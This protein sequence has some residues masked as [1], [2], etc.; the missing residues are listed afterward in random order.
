M[1]YNSASRSTES[2]AQRNAPGIAAVQRERFKPHRHE[3]TSLDIMQIK[4]V[5]FTIL[6]V[7]AITASAVQSVSAQGNAAVD[8]AKVLR[9]AGDALGMNRW[10]DIG[11]G[12]T[13]L[14]A[15]DI[16]NTMEFVGSGTSYSS[17]QTFKTDYHVTLGYNPPA[18]RVEMA[19][20]GSGGGA[21][22]HSI[23]TVR[24]NYAWNESEIGGGLVPGKGTATPAMPALKERLLELWTLPYGV[25]K[26]ALAAGDKTTV[27][28][29]NGATVITLPLSGQLGGI[30]VK[31]T[32]DSKNFVTK[33]ETRPDN[34]ALAN[35]ATE[36]EYSGYAD[37]GEVLTDINSP[38]RI[39]KKQGGRPILDIQVS[40]WEAN[41]PYLVFPV[42]PNVKTAA[43][44]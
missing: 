15:I 38:G 22:Q 44:R 41:N 40:M 27:S 36:T 5:V 21:P 12:G 34:P 11:A 39:V 30:T 8:R 37:H 43:S 25:V 2:A 23:Q 35:M 16:V 20:T 29:E 9:A 24:E 1:D 26:S 18:M 32:L 3:R 31:A 4:T 7:V 19:R 17:G 28:T 33:V 10:S 13:R 14:P 42:P 6:I